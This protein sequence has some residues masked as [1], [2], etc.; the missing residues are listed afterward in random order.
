MNFSN[1][2][3]KV[4]Y[5]RTPEREGM[6]FLNPRSEAASCSPYGGVVRLIKLSTA[7]ELTPLH[8]CG[9]S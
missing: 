7:V 1:L 8:L 4:R 9:V 3:G 5:V 2:L 6:G